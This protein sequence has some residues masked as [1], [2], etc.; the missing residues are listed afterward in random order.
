MP[1]SVEPRTVPRLRPGGSLMRLW[2]T[3]RRLKPGQV[4]FRAWRL[5]YRGRLPVVHLPPH[6]P[7]S[8][9]MTPWIACARP[10]SMTGPW[11]LS[12]F[13][14]SHD[15]ARAGWVPVDKSRLW[16]YNLHYFDDLVSDH[17]SARA[18]WH[19]DLIALWMEANPGPFGTGWEP[20][21]TAL[22]ITN[23][24]QW[25]LA[26]GRGSAAIDASLC[27][28]AQW[29]SSRLEWHLLGNHLW[30]DAKA[31]VFAG[32]YFDGPKA[33]RWLARGLA[34]VEKELDEQLLD[35]GGHFERS[36]MYH[37]IVLKDLL[38]L[39]QL[40]TLFPDQVP[41]LL[42]ERLARDAVRMRRWQHALAHPDGELAF[43]NDSTFGVAPDRRAL[44]AYAAAILP[45]APM[46]AGVHEGLLA[47]SGFARLARGSAVCLVDVGSVAPDYLPGHAHA[48]T[49][50]FELSRGGQRV[51]VNAGIS[52]YA[53]GDQRLAERG[54]ALHNTL[55]LG[56]ADSSEVW[57]SFRVGAR[58]RVRDVDYSDAGSVTQV[59]ATHDGYA[60]LPGQPLHRR[61]LELGD[62]GLK[63][64]DE[65]L[66]QADHGDAL[67]GVVRFRLH[68]AW[69]ASREAD[70]V[71]LRLG[72]QRICF[73]H[74]GDARTRI[75]QGTWHPGFGRSEPCMVLEV[76]VAETLS[77][78]FWFD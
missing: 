45:L 35:D 21:P 8:P 24:I 52:T 32:A 34:L 60:W 13:D 33:G 56:G 38:D 4:W 16:S 40:G 64:V 19:Q 5:A 67:V 71:V 27:A 46:Q 78:V 58:A 41:A 69:A 74:S 66:A 63:V 37:A 12:F 53:V 3:V 26:G 47:D 49:L 10:A 1:V 42:R 18:A 39:I 44:D 70:A 59:V 15:V 77:S 11:T 7:R 14:E 51:L 65:I 22:R 6:R 17:A 61:R 25:L 28:Q 20:Y 48:G 50:C 23:W 57:G 72:S 73:E 55:Q 76:D 62:S 31:L 68:P 43:F 36:P 75:V 9:R 54:T 29:L 30:T 2:R